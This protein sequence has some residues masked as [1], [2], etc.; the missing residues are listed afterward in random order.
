MTM[1]NAEG[2]ESR[3]SFD[4]NHGHHGGPLPIYIEP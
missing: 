4:T 1:T 2:E 3:E